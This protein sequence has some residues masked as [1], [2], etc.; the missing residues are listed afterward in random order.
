MV[1][2]EPGV[3]LDSATIVVR[4]GRIVE[5]GRNAVIPDDAV[6]YNLHGKY[7]YPSFIELDASFGLPGVERDRDRSRG[8]QMLSKKPGAYAWNEALRTEFDAG[9]AFSHDEKD[10]AE[11]RKAGFGAILTHRPDGISRGTGA[12]VSTAEKREHESILHAPASHHLSFSKGSS[13]QDYP[14]SLM[15][16]IALI[17][18]A[19]YDAQWY[20]SKEN[21]K[22]RNYSLEAWG[23]AMELPQFF[24]VGNWQ[25]ALRAQ[26]I[27]DEFKHKYIVRGSGDEY[28]RVDD[29]VKNIQRFIVP[30]DFPEPY[31]LD[32]PYD[33]EMVSLAEMLHWE[34]APSNAAR[35]VEGGAEIALTS[36]GLKKRENFR[37]AVE[38]AIEAGLKPEDALRALTVTPATWLGV[39]NDVGTLAEG[40]WANMLVTEGQIFTKKGK[41]LDNWVQ[42]AR[43]SM[44]PTRKDDIGG[45]YQLVIGDMVVMLEVVEGDKR[46]MHI[47]LG[48][49]TK[50]PVDHAYSQGV[51][52]M[53]FKLSPEKDAGRYR[54][55]G[56]VGPGG[57]SGTGLSDHGDE[58]HWS[59]IPD[60]G[61][62]GIDG[63][64]G[65]D[66]TDG[67]VTD[68][69]VDTVKGEVLYPFNGYGWSEKPQQESVFIQNATVWTN[70]AAGILEGADVL[71]RNGKIVEVGQGLLVPDDAIF[72]NG[73]GKHVTS[74]IIDE[75]THIAISR[76]VNE[77]TQESS[78]EVRIGDVVN[79]EDINIYRQLAG[80]VVAAQLLHGSA[81][82][83]GG[84]SAIIKFRW[85]FLP[86]AMKI[87]DA[88]R[89]IKFALGEN[90]KQSN[91]GDNNR[92]RFPQTRMGV[93]Q[94]YDDYFTR[95][96]RYSLGKME[97][98]NQRVDLEME[99]LAEI[100]NGYRFISC[101]SYQQGEINMLMKVAE[102][103]GFTVNTFTHILEGY[104]VADKM[105]EHGAGGSSFSDWWAYKYEVKDAIPYNGAIM[106]REGVT[107]AFNSDDREMARRLNQEAAKAIQYGGVAEEDAWKFVTLNPARLLHL[108]HRMGSLK[109]GKDADVVIWSDNP[110]SMYAVAETTWVDGIRF[111]DREADREKRQRI[112][113]ERERL[114]R[115]MTAAGKKDKNGRKP[116]GRETPD[117]HCDSL[118]DEG[119]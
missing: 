3:Q 78:A 115:K 109:K 113:A 22:E 8:P 34:H 28:Q 42:G 21:R 96:N 9:E 43:Y 63:T 74:G 84:Q 19:H 106:H 59:A 50:I 110:L 66:G 87:A 41:I 38:R 77:G 100:L 5:I 69:R 37:E 82:P 20:A 1:V 6:V 54:L 97:D 52:S 103:H 68:T 32:D 18:Q 101:H 31:E 94:V 85:G 11:W 90:V 108:D 111:F 71:F 112:A 102:K 99:A 114:T 105:A 35:L 16:T 27:G 53:R 98:K 39:A 107:V 10:A 93:E 30:L 80:G 83:I 95:A 56:A 23:K 116:K 49:T 25:E 13:P 119:R 67:K 26:K 118:H 61:T 24:A 12:L 17:R 48:D 45:R 73:T 76:G 72:I 81:N 62:E 7:V 36:S 60:D 14:S 89:F 92:T 40:K 33:A 47:R 65:T 75:H 51:I 44:A 79:S 117:Y 55:A 29:L 46:K 91:W 15:G 58:L 64:D 70:E 88:P 4:K 104:K 86:E 57:W 2:T